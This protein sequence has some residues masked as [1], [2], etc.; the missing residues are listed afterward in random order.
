MRASGVREVLIDCRDHW[1]SHHVEVS[2]DSLAA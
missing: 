2:A 1:C